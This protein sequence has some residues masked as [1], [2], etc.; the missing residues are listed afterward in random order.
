MEVHLKQNIGNMERLSGLNKSTVLKVQST[1]GFIS[2]SG[3]MS[4]YMSNNF[5]SEML[6]HILQPNLLTYSFYKYQRLSI[7]EETFV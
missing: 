2:S 1:P 4:K 3:F 7:I 5:R 6:L